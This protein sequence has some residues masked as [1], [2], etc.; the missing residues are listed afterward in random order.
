M[1]RMFTFDFSMLSLGTASTDFLHS[2]KGFLLL[3][4]GAL[5]LV[6]IGFL[7]LSPFLC[8]TRGFFEALG[9]RC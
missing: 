3:F 2:S 4:Q 9:R 5:V 6:F 8:R 7:P 1:A